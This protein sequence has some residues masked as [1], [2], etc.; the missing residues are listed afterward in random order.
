MTN[1]DLGPKPEPEIEP[2][3]PNPG[4]VDAIDEDPMPEPVIPDLTVAK[5]PAVDEDAAPEELSEGEDTSTDATEDA[6]GSEG[7]QDP[8]DAEEEAPV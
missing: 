7:A 2:G 6:D 4:G 8:D 3:E 5:N 1:D